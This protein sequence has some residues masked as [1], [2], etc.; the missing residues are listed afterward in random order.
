MTEVLRQRAPLNSLSLPT[1]ILCNV[2]IPLPPSLSFPL[3]SPTHTHTITNHF[4]SSL[5]ACTFTH[6]ISILFQMWLIN[7]L[8]FVA[9]GISPSTNSVN[10]YSTSLCTQTHAQLSFFFFFNSF[11]IPFPV[12]GTQFSQPVVVHLIVF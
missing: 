11:L 4:L 5:V 10:S 6:P 1:K 7:Q 9:T 3:P 8:Y 12:K 2:K